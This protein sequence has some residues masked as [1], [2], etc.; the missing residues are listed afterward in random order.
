MFSKTQLC[1]TKHCNVTESEGKC[2]SCSH[3]HQAEH[4]YSSRE[5]TNAVLSNCLSGLMLIWYDDECISG[6]GGGGL[7][8]ELIAL[9]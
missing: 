6:R 4:R 8:V 9:V 5:R 7:V 3:D 1:P 2:H